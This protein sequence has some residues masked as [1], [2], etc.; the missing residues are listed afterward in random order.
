MVGPIRLDDGDTLQ[1]TAVA[2]GRYVHDRA[3]PGQTDYVL[4]ARAD[5]LYYSGLPNP[6]PYNW[7]LMLRAAPHAIPRLRALLA[8]SQRPTWV[9]EW[10]APP[11][12]GLDKG[13]A[14]GQLLA[15]HYTRVA[16]V[17]GHP[18]LLARGARARPAPSRVR[19]A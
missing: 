10:Q 2:V 13:G 19:C 18:L 4:Y 7:S 11:A 12:F 8:S 16:R 6:Y 5:V 17:C 9:V 14:T 1:R 15:R 3:E